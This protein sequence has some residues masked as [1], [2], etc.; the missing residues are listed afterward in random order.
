MPDVLDRGGGEEKAKRDA[1]KQAAEDMGKQ[2]AT[3]ITPAIRWAYWKYLRNWR[4]CGEKGSRW[5]VKDVVLAHKKLAEAQQEGNEKAAE[6][7]RK[8]LMMNGCE[9]QLS[10]GERPTDSTENH[11]PHES[12][13]GGGTPP[14]GS[15]DA[16]DQPDVRAGGQGRLEA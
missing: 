7:L 13:N 6:G 11:D 10:D 15:G 5:A 3:G 16:P 14:S 8:F 2:P 12:G 9:D 1:A 4:R